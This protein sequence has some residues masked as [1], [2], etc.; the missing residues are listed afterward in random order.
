MG[1]ASSKPAAKRRHRTSIRTMKADLADILEDLKALQSTDP[2]LTDADAFLTQA[3]VCIEKQIV[4][5]GK[6]D[7]PAKA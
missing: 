6:P 4:T 5:E 2:Y 1:K 7:A 3:I